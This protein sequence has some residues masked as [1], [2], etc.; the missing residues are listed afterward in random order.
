[1]MSV[2]IFSEQKK[3]RHPLA[4]VPQTGPQWYFIQKYHFGPFWGTVARGWALEQDISKMRVSDQDFWPRW[5]KISFSTLMIS[6]NLIVSKKSRHPL[7]TIPQNGPKWYFRMKYHFWPFWGCV[8]WGW[9]LKMV[10]FENEVIRSWLL[11]QLRKKKTSIQILLTSVNIVSNHKI[12]TSPAEIV[13]YKNEGV[14]SGFL[15][16]SK[17]NRLPAF[18]NVS[19]YF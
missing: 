2:N 10:S 12:K 8:V 15:L 13:Y 5:Q 1:M 17:K 16:K 9:D 7:V 3:S 4:T 14:W 18:A 19:E 11:F 6:L